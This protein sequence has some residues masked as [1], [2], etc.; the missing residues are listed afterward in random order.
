MCNRKRHLILPTRPLTTRNSATYGCQTTH[1]ASPNG[2]FRKQKRAF[3]GEKVHF[4]GNFSRPFQP[5]IPRCIASKL[6]FRHFSWSKKS[7]YFL[8]LTPSG[9]RRKKRKRRCQNSFSSIV[10]THYVFV[11]ILT[12][13]RFGINSKGKSHTPHHAFDSD[14]AQVAGNGSRHPPTI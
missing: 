10:R 8:T 12:R 9:L 14:R 6:L 3:S 11:S 2:L 5:H 1:L 4:S 13:H 7:A